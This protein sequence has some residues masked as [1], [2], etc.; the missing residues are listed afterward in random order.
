MNK[1]VFW[2]CGVA[3]SAI[4]FDALIMYLIEWLSAEPPRCRN[5]NSVNPLKLVDCRT[6]E[7]AE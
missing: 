2:L 7:N 6:L 3:L 1:K 5:M 4:L